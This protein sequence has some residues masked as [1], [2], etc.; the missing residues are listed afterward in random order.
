MFS[1]SSNYT[2]FF[3]LPV[4]VYIWYTLYMH[5][6]YWM[7]MSWIDVVDFF[8]HE[9]WHILFSLFWN[10]FLSVAGWTLLQLIIPLLLLLYFWKQKDY[11]AVSLCFAW[12]WTNFFY[13]SMYS[14]DAVNMNLPL[15]S[16]WWWEVIHDWFYMF[17][18]LWIINHTSLISNIFYYIAIWLFLF[19]FIF[20]WILIIN[21]FREGKI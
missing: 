4:L 10:E 14:W 7:Y 9:F 6:N 17:S 1:K 20:S 11:F 16:M 18:N 21:R 3:T 13:I 15:I 19:C 5:L 12:I 2:V 8:I